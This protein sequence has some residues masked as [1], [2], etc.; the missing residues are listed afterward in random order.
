M[1]LLPGYSILLFTGLAFF[2]G[3]YEIPPKIPEAYVGGETAPGWPPQAVYHSDPFHP[4]NLLFQR[5]FILNKHSES[6]DEVDRAEIAVLV[7][8]LNEDNSLSDKGREDLKRDLQK[9]SQSL[10]ERAGEGDL[11]VVMVLDGFIEKLEK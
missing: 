4:A 2:A 10:R 7:L 1:G 11:E 9:R 6:F 5:L 8:R 3:C